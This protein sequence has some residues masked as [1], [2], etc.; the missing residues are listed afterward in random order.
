MPCF[1]KSITLVTMTPFL[2]IPRFMIPWETYTSACSCVSSAPLIAPEIMEPVLHR[3]YNVEVYLDDIGIFFKTWEERLFL[4][5]KVLSLLK[6]NDFTVTFLNMHGVYKKP[7]AWQLA[8]TNQKPTRNLF[9]PFLNK[10][11]HSASRKCIVSL[12]M[13]TL[14]N[15]CGLNRPI[16]WEN[17]LLNLVESRF[18]GL[19]KG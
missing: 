18:F 3:F 4:L 17:C 9:L 11:H 12:V 2:G 6:A 19:Q 13:L 10:N 5:E 14:T 1:H 8:C 16:C 7:M 15:S